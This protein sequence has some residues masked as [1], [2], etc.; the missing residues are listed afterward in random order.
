MSTRRKVA[1]W[2]LVG[3]ATVLT[4]VSSLTVW[5]KRQLLNTDAWTNTSAQMLADPTIRNAVSNKLVEN[6]FQ[7]VDVAGELRAQL[8]KG[9]QGIAPAAAV[10]LQTAAVRATDA[11]LAT[12]RAQALWENANRR[13]HGA[14]LRV[15]EGK[16]VGPI[17]TANGAVVLDV[18]PMLSN[19]ATR[20][21]IGDKLKARASPS[22]GQIV[23]LRSDQ[24]GAA[25]DAV[26]ALR[27]LSVFLAL[28]VLALFGGAIALARGHRRTILQA[29]GAALV[30]VGL[31]LLVVRRVAGN[32]IVDSVVNT[33]A[34]R[35]PIR[36]A[37][38][39]ETAM[40]RD[41]ALGLVL[42]GIFALL[43]AW[44]AGPSRPAVASRR[45]LAPTFRRSP[46]IMQTVGFLIFLVVVAWG[47][48]AGSRRL[49][50]LLILWAI[51]IVGIEALRRQ[52]L[53]EFPVTPVEGDV[54]Y[55]AAQKP[56][57]N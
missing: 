41:I 18:R 26:Q 16:T 56:A 12:P 34:N 8:P 19:V 48:T 9:A 6:L 47:P 20:L 49:W 14:L 4:L 40:L 52:T 38:L 42:Y 51:V 53:R 2:S 7:R 29:T 55:E 35:P 43:G 39:L 50:G 25:Q 17:S 57:L 22:T 33:E 11:F 37:W 28:A 32:A 5:T 15:L 21:G 46:I 3:L 1:V 24:L 10:A 45:W 31:I 27:V 36:I 44:V 23:L 54:A 30:V 13:A